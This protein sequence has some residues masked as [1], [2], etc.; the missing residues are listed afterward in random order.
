MMREL[1]RTSTTISTYQQAAFGTL[2]T[3]TT[4]HGTTI[5]QNTNEGFWLFKWMQAGAFFIKLVA[6]HAFY[7]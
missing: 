3:C 1:D 4:L 6:F 7:A 5:T 2:R